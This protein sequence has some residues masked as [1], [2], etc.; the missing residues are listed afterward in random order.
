VQEGL[1]TEDAVFLVSPHLPGGDLATRLASAP[2]RRLPIDRVLAIAYDLAL[3]LA[4]THGR[5]VVH[6]DVS[7]GNVLLDADERACL[8]DFGLA[9]RVSDPGMKELRG[10]PGYLAPETIRG[11]TS[12]FASDLYAFGCVIFE[13]LAGRSPFVS[14]CVPDLLRR[15]QLA[16]PPDLRKLRPDTPR[17]LATL[18]HALMAKDP[19]GARS[20]R[21][22]SSEHS[23][24]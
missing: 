16:R 18:V 6:G 12:G 4:H 13:T 17:L 2:E 15:H 5:E 8:S 24:A 7:P 9:R 10:T 21:S 14:D 19:R 23:G 3:A 11:E 22:M 20:L 1:E